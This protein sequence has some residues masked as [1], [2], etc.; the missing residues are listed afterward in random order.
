ML[1]SIRFTIICFSNVLSPRHVSPSWILQLK[2]FPNSSATVANVSARSRNNVGEVQ[3]SEPHL[4]RSAFDLGNAQERRKRIEYFV[5]A[6]DRD[7]SM[8]DWLLSACGSCCAR[9]RSCR[10]LLSGVREVMGDVV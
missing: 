9:S 7:V 6:G 3:K 10:S 1:F 5:D 8:S 4:P 2:T